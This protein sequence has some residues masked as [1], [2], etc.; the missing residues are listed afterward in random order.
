[1]LITLEGIEGS[2]KS[3]QIKRI[4]AH[5]EKKG[6]RCVT[7]REP[8]DTSIGKKIRAI[9]LDPENSELTSLAELFLYAADRAQHL[10]E[11][12]LPHLSAG[13]VVV[14]DRFF[15][16]TTAYQGYARGLDLEV[17]EKIH[18]MVLK[19]LRP[20][21]TLLLDL[22]P[23]VGLGR[24]ISAIESGDRT[25]DESRFEQEALAFHE[26]VRAGYL[27]LAH[28]EPE[29]FVVIDATV[30]PDEVTDAITRAID[31]RLARNKG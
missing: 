12:V 13:D 7:T 3:T 5:L 25:V 14:S 27:A 24:A 29:R 28:R 18:T 20:D 10:G 1:M 30:S 17:I 19:G 8:G 6:R 16:A 15:D 9:L 23:E 26:K 4:T 21:L 31:D 11:R 2:G 22:P